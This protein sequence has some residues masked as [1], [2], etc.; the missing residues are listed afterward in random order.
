M[1][2]AKYT[3]WSIIVLFLLIIIGLKLLHYY[4]VFEALRV[5]VSANP[6][7]VFIFVICSIVLLCLDFIS[8]IPSFIIIALNANVLGL[9]P[10]LIVSLTGLLLASIAA[11]FMASISS[12]LIEH[13]IPVLKKKKDYWKS[14]SILIVS[15]AIPG[16]SELV[17]FYYGF[18]GYSFYKFVV[19]SFLGYLPLALVFSLF[20][21]SYS[22]VLLCL[23]SITACIF[24]SIMIFLS[25]KYYP[26][27]P[28]IL[29]INAAK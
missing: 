6:A 19:F 23:L 5:Y 4:Q 13:H 3:W 27:I 7:H 9:G 18:K 25:K 21:S 10:G 16:V 12:L 22:Y 29:K 2:P 11:Y 8:P 24:I 15:K 28:K 1:N 26:E 20:D 17:S 14:S